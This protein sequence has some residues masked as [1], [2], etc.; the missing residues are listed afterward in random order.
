[1]SYEMNLATTGFFKPQKTSEQ[2]SKDEHA[3]TVALAE[4]CVYRQV[5]ATQEYLQVFSQRLA[6]EH[7]PGVL[8][9]IRKLGEMKREEG[10]TALPS[11]GT[12][13]SNRPIRMTW[14]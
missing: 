3:I 6:Q 14:D 1:M 12:I 13:L 2:F 8:A 7:L 9:S 11:L 4:M 5:V 10:E